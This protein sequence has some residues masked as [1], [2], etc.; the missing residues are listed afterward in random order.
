M[1]HSNHYKPLAIDLPRMCIGLCIPLLLTVSGCSVEPAKPSPTKT[2]AETAKSEAEHFETKIENFCG[3]CHGVPR[4]SS[5]PKDAWAE[6]VNQGFRLFLNSGR[7]DLDPPTPQG[8]VLEYYQDN[9]PETLVLER[10]QH[11]D[12]PMSVSFH[13]Q[14]I[15]ILID[16]A[17]VSVATVRWL[18]ESSGE[19]KVTKKEAGILLCDMARGHLMHIPMGSKMDGSTTDHVQLDAKLLETFHNI[20]SVEP[21]DLDRDSKL[22]YLL[23]DLGSY[24]PSDHSKGKVYWL[25]QNSDG[26]WVKQILLHR[27]GRVA[28]VKAADFDGDQKTDIVVSEFGWRKT[29]SVIFLRNQTTDPDKPKF[30]K[31][32][33]DERSGAIQIH[34]CDL[35]ND[36][37]L[38]FVTVLSQEHELVMGYLNDGKGHFKP[39]LIWAADFPSYGSNGVELVDLDDDGDL[40]ILYTNGDAFDDN[41]LKPYFAIQWLENRGTYP[42]THHPIA[43]MPGVHRAL[44]ADFDG[45]GDLDIIACALLPTLI[46]NRTDFSLDSVVFLENV[47]GQYMRHSLEKETLNHGSLDVGDFDGDGDLDFATGE[48]WPL[49]KERSVSIWWNDLQAKQPHAQEASK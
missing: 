7:T 9:A 44:P 36:G 15:P 10:P 45:D 19:V 11:S 47:E 3:A 46:K 16:D 32:T 23:A 5:F 34:T 18:P 35:N 37:H 26:E 25:H 4:P 2:T 12:T 39:Q 42:Y 6:E 27:V 13:R 29:G 38:D 30:A 49:S 1:T 43:T 22:D 17:A 20:A 24:A 21:T 41:F 14:D 31:E 8:A 33:I 40:D 48:F 28:F